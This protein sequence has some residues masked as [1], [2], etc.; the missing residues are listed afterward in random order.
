MQSVG[1]GPPAEEQQVPTCTR[2]PDRETY[3]S[4]QRCG[5]PICPECMNEAAV[6]FQ[7]P[8]CVAEGRRGQP[9]VR[10]AYGGGIHARDTVVTISLI[11]T[12]IA[13]FVAILATGGSASDLGEALSMVSGEVRLFGLPPDAGVVHGEY[14]RILT[15]AFV[16]IETYH[17]LFNMVAIGFIGSVL[18][19]LLGRW[20]YL[21]LYL[22]SCLVAGATVYWLSPPDAMTYGASGGVFGLL[23]A[24]LVIFRKQ[25]Y[26]TQ[27]LLL[28]LG[29]NLVL[30]FTR[31]SISWQ[32]HIGGLVGGLAVAAALA[33][34]P[35]GRRRAVHA[36]AIVA[37]TVVS[38]ALI[39]IR[40]LVLD[41]P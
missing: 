20:R 29:F 22:V 34:A 16:H 4:C 33:Y 10:T 14:W 39:A 25:G 31:G 15:S 37:I 17:L 18:E 13:V 40:T 6:G 35:R 38:L 2:H 32:G 1:G 5:R 11:A 21:A 27:W 24:A 8:D 26:D 19:R 9:K 12:N 23:A 7:C 3:I 30:T 36:S 28:L 41:V